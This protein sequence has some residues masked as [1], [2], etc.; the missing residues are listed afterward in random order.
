MHGFDEEMEAS[1]DQDLCV[2]IAKRG[3]VVYDK[4]VVTFTSNRR[5]KK[6][7]LFGLTWDWGKTTLNFLIGIKTKRYAIIRE[8]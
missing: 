8:I 2:R 4:N 1:E 6:F 5:L 3:A 7:G